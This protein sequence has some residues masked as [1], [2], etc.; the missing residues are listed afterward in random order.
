MT[1]PRKAPAERRLAGAVLFLK[2]HAF[3]AAS[4]VLRGDLWKKVSR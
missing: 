2:V 1:T 3:L 4:T